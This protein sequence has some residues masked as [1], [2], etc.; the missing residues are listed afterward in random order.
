M[1]GY[2]FAS[3]WRSEERQ[4]AKVFRSFAVSFL[5]MKGGVLQFARSLSI[6]ADHLGS[7]I[8]IQTGGV[9]H[10]FK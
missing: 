6:R 7:L 1:Q 10:K 4:T 8:A 5:E 2:G 3:L 9:N